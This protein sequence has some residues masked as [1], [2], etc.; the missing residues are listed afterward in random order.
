[1]RFDSFGFLFG[2]VL[3]A[4]VEIFLQFLGI[5]EQRVGY[6]GPILHDFAVRDRMG[7]VVFLEE[8]L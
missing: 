4:Q 1:M 2:G 5:G 3:M 8:R 6:G 7:S